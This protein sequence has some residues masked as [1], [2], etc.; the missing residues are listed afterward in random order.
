MKLKK[1]KTKNTS[2][3]LREKWKENLF[4]SSSTL[5]QFFFIQDIDDSPASPISLKRSASLSCSR[6]LFLGIYLHMHSV[7]S[8]TGK[9]DWPQERWRGCLLR[10][11]AAEAPPLSAGLHSDGSEDHLAGF[12]P[13]CLSVSFKCLQTMWVLKT[14]LTGYAS[15]ALLSLGYRD[16]SYK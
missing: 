1:K 4:S 10:S 2:M 16:F 15:I 11:E 12:S 7:D 9:A 14:V 3:Y 8:F 5:L 6:C 13:S